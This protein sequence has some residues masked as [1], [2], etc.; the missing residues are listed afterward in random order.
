MTPVERVVEIPFFQG[1][2]AEALREVAAGSS[3]LTLERGKTV[4]SQNDVAEHV[5]FLLSG[6]VQCYMLFQGVD[7]LLVGTV[8]EPGSLV[9]WSLFRPPYRY[10]ATVRCENDCRLLRVPREVVSS[11]IEAQP[12]LGYI[13]L[14]RVASALANRLEQTRDILV[15]P[16]ATGEVPSAGG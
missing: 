1:L 10:T 11:L 4:V 16:P 13:L 2:S 5:Y 14:K 8:S 7:D 6:R 9:G 12:R 3:Y 15:R